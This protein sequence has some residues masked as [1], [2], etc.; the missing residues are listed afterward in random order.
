MFE[1][2]KSNSNFEQTLMKGHWKAIIAKS[3]IKEQWDTYVIK[4]PSKLTHHLE[5]S[6]YVNFLG[7]L[8][9]SGFQLKRRFGTMATEKNQNPGGRF[10]ATS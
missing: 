2:P 10:G 1:C 3:P 4:A 5:I 7:C 9:S 6:Y 8:G